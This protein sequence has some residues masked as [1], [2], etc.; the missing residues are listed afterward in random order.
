MLQV[1]IQARGEVVPKD[2][3]PRQVWGKDFVDDSNL[4][5]AISQIRKALD[6]PPAGKSYK[7]LS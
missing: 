6:P 2:E 5:Q 7:L 1:L 4:T 3:I